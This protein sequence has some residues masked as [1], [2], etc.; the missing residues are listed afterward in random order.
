MNM[1]AKVGYREPELSIWHSCEKGQETRG[2]GWA[3][4]AEKPITHGEHTAL[5]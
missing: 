4:G 2:A 1:V 5:K 3:G